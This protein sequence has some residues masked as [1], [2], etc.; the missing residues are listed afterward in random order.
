MPNDAL[1]HRVEWF[2][3]EYGSYKLRYICFGLVEIAISTNSKPKIYRNLCENMNYIAVNMISLS[4]VYQL[5]MF[6][7]FNHWTFESAFV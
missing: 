4:Y 7:M 3:R 2:V 5:N 6:N 1:M